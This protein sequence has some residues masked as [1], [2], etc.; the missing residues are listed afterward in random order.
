MTIS[1]RMG[2]S[3]D[4]LL[5]PRW[6]LVTHGR[7]DYRWHVRPAGVVAV[8][9]W[10]ILA[11][12]IGASRSADQRVA[13]GSAPGGRPAKG[14]LLVASSDLEDPNFARSVVLLVAH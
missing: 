9:T 2:V 10:C 3:S 11:A 14:K 12:P 4:L 5:W 1:G 8:L 7:P 6:R 13:T